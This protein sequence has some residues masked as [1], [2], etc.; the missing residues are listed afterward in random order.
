MN[1]SWQ[2]LPIFAASSNSLFI[3]S[4]VW[5]IPSSSFHYE[6]R[7]G[8]PKLEFTYKKLVYFSH[9]FKLQPPANYSPSDAMHLL[10]CFSHCSEQFLNSSILTLF[11]ASA[12][13]C[14][15]SFM[16]AKCSL[17]RAFFIQGNKKKIHSR[18]VWVNR[19][20]R[21]P[22]SCHFGSKTA[23]HSARY[24]QMCP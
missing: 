6:I 23:E 16:S 15:P 14:F 12:V 1:T 5:H 7:G 4:I 2:L 10:S 8:P 24:G 19:E 13:F 18:R 17:L 22:G 3:S 20:G 21:A 11:S 9:M